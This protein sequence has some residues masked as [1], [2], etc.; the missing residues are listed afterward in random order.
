MT[1]YAVW[2]VLSFSASICLASGA[3]A[4][5][6][7]GAGRVPGWTALAALVASLWIGLSIVL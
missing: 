5:E 4:Q 1:F 2:G 6:V 3:L 7:F